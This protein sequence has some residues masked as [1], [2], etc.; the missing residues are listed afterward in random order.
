MS[1]HSLNSCVR[2]VFAVV[3][4]ASALPFDFIS[5]RYSVIELGKLVSGW[6][7]PSEPAQSSKCFSFF[8]PCVSRIHTNRRFTNSF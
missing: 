8:K 5:V 4:V 6:A 2:R 3:L 1:L 7:I